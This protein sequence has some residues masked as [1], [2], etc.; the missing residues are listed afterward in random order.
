MTILTK[1]EKDHT[2]DGPTLIADTLTWLV[3]NSEHIVV[4]QCKLLPEISE[5]VCIEL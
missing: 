4:K 3:S 1:T 2:L 5:P